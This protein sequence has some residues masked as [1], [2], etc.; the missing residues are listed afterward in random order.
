MPKT[1]QHEYFVRANKRNAQRGGG[2]QAN[3]EIMEMHEFIEQ[4]N[5]FKQQ[6]VMSEKNSHRGDQPQY[7]RLEKP[8][9]KQEKALVDQQT[10]TFNLENNGKSIAIT[11]TSI[12]DQQSENVAQTNR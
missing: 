8:D 1:K 12:A 11:L 2:Q 3:N 6:I 5:T 9:S 10:E 7:R 4:V